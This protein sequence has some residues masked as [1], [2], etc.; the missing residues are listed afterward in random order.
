MIF[1]NFPI[2]SSA[3]LG[4]HL[5]DGLLEPAVHPISDNIQESQHP[6]LG[7]VND[8][9]LFLQERVGACRS[10]VH[11]G[12]Y[13]CR[14][15]NVSGDA[16]GGDVRTRLG[17]KPV[18]GSSPVAHMEVNIDKARRDVQAGYINHFLRLARRNG[19]GNCRNL[20]G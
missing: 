12:R 15:R 18:K 1:G 6:D 13:S 8:F 5:L 2:V 17:C 11:N 14:Q 16:Q 19:L 4:I 10:R 9:L 7:M 20:P 3:E